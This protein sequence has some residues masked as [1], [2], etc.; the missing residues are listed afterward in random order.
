MAIEYMKEDNILEV[1]D[2]LIN[3]YKTL[4]EVL[5]G[6]NTVFKVRAISMM[7]QMNGQL[8]ERLESYSET[9]KN[10]DKEN[11]ELLKTKSE[12]F[13]KVGEKVKQV[14]EI[15]ETTDKLMDKFYP[16]KTKMA[17]KKRS[18]FKK[19]YNKTIRD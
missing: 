4:N 11:L 16:Q 2:N 7:R 9:F 1:M 15:I 5:K 19:F 3:T 8:E 6:S 13:K 10:L 14:E 17:K 18:R 12:E